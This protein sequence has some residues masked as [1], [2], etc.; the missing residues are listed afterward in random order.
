MYET[1]HYSYMPVVYFEAVQQQ[2]NMIDCG[3]RSHLD[4]AETCTGLQYYM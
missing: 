4:C 3:V 2:N 1:I